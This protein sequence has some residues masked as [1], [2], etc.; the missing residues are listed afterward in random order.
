MIELSNK[1]WMNKLWVTLRLLAMNNTNV[2]YS[3]IHFQTKNIIVRFINEDIKD[4]KDIT[5][6]NQQQPLTGSCLVQTHT[7]WQY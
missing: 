4:I 2:V 3:V 7:E 1:T 5:E 6:S